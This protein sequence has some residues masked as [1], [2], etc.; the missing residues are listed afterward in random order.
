MAL[1]LSSLILARRGSNPN[2]E[3]GMRMPVTKDLI[4]LF[5]WYKRTGSKISYPGTP[6]PDPVPGL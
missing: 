4:S 3:T 2:P 5:N 6:C 1:I